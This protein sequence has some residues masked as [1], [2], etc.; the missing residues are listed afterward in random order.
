MQLS[1]RTKRNT[2]STLLLFAAGVV[3]DGLRM[4]L[5]DL[6]GTVFILLFLMWSGQVQERTIERNVKRRLTIVAWLL[7]MLFFLRSCRY[8]YFRELPEAWQRA[9]WYF[10]YVP[11]LFMTALGLDIAVC[12]VNAGNGSAGEH[13]GVVYVFSALLSALIVTNELHHW[14]FFPRGGDWSAGYG[15]GGA[16]F[17]AVLYITLC[18]AYMLFLL[19]REYRRSHDKHRYYLQP[20]GVL[21]VAAVFFV[22]YYFGLLPRAN[23][24]ELVKLQD[25]VA[26]LVIG[27]MESCL[28]IG[29]IPMARIEEKSAELNDTRRQYEQRSR[30]YDAMAESVMP[31]ILQIDSILDREDS[32]DF[33]LLLARACVL[34][35]YVKRRCNLMLQAQNRES[36]PLEEL[37]YS[38]AE[39]LEYLGLCHIQ[40]G[41]FSVGGGEL[42]IGR[43]LDAYAFFEQVTESILDGAEALLVNLELRGEALHMRLTVENPAQPPECR[44]A[45]GWSVILEENTWYIDAMFGREAVT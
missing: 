43:I 27:L 14:A 10:Y 39:S 15:H 21:A 36:V 45:P 28:N 40:G 5:F 38:I 37:R 6:G 35:A 25:V 19:I 1:G 22:L 4:P 7:V 12:V 11:F 26:L 32:P 44:P 18:I 23:G 30:L 20:L 24:R 2:L 9:A 8:I 33:D 29:L 16:Y 42:G 34:N 17:A 31:Q 13:L 41:V 3:L